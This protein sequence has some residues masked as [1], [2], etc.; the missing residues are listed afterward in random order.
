MIK[1]IYCLRRLPQLT[2]EDFQRHWREIHG[3][4]VKKHA[5]V[6]KIQHYI[7]IHTKD[8]AFNEAARAA[9]GAPEP[10]DGV[11][12]LCWKSYEEMTAAF[13]SPAGQKAA[14]ELLEDEKLFID[15]SKSPVWTTPEEHVFVGNARAG[16]KS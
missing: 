14:A 3:P 15:L 4:M 7:Q 2:R 10:Y 9:R 6:L 16:N 1:L 8:S 11:A 5:K 12:E 13:S